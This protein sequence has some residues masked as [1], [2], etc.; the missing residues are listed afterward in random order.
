MAKILVV[1]LNPAWQQ[2][3][4]LPAIPAGGVIRA[5][6]FWSLGSGKGLNAAKVLARR[7]HEVSLLQVLAGE[8]GRRVLASC[9]AFGVRS[10]E[11]WAGGET[12]TCVTLLRE[13]GADEVIAPFRV[14]EEHGASVADALLARVSSG[15]RFDALV[16]CGSIPEGIDEGIYAR[17]VERISAP[18]LVWDSVQGLAPEIVPRISWVKLN[19]HEYNGLARAVWRHAPKRPAL[20]THSSGAEIRNHPDAGFARFP[21]LRRPLNP[22]GAGDTATAIL[23]DGILRGLSARAAASAALA[24]ASAS[25]QNPLPSEWDAEDAERFEGE[26]RWEKIENAK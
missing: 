6:A 22:I 18:L 4:R 19:M 11:A 8:N 21:E 23:T 25:C 24:A 7:G 5:E 9:E 15:E 13:G 14:G 12:R 17:I 20:M 16:V 2:V 26:I 1:G 3:F 10:L